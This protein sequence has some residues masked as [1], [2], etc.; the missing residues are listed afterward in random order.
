MLN[1]IF[2][3]KDTGELRHGGRKDTLEQKIGPWGWSDDDEWLTLDEMETGF[4]AVEDSETKKWT[5]FLDRDRARTAR[6]WGHPTDLEESKSTK[7]TKPKPTKSPKPKPTK[8]TTP[9]TSTTL[10]TPATPTTSTASTNV[11][12]QG[13]N[14]QG[15]D[16]GRV[17]TMSQRWAA[18]RLQRKMALG[19][20]SKWVRDSDRKLG[21]TR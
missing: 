18:V 14:D 16:Q 17:S 11:N 7:S 13:G 15:N 10:T 12:N 3:D 9:T 1:W 4:I 21:E 20:D 8:P 6:F 5:I 2:V 19:M